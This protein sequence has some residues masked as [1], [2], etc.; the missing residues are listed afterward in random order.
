MVTEVMPL[1]TAG[2]TRAACTGG[3]WGP[4]FTVPRGQGVSPDGSHLETGP[5]QVA[6]WCLGML[7]KVER[8]ALYSRHDDLRKHQCPSYTRGP[9]STPVSS[10]HD[11][12]STVALHASA[13]IFFWT[14]VASPRSQSPGGQKGPEARGG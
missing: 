9:P 14:D 6:E 11:G 8:R 10:C 4:A 5:G 12:K 1:R 3:V 2:L 13:A 7:R